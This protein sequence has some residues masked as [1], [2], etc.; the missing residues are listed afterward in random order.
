M[1]RIVIT[2]IVTVGVLGLGAA[3]AGASVASKKPSPPKVDAALRNACFT[4]ITLNFVDRA[5]SFDAE[6][7]AG[8]ARQFEQSKVKGASKLGKRFEKVTGPTV[9]YN[10]VLTDASDFCIKH[11]IDTSP[12]VPATT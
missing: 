1:R 9:A 6:S 11:G 7:I 5:Q 3:G 2:V 4:V 12:Y 10:L 8:M